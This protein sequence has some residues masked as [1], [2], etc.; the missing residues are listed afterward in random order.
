MLNDEL[1]AATVQ[2]R[3][4]SLARGLGGDWAL[5][6]AFGFGHGGHVEPFLAHSSRSPLPTKVDY[7][8]ED[9]GNQVS[10]TLFVPNPTLSLCP[11]SMTTL[12]G[13]MALL[14]WQPV[15]FPIPISPLALAGY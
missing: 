7:E 9:D 6:S 11:R 2:V 1:L 14:L 13:H 5:I 8:Y 3:Y 15:R 10:D 12:P 4:T